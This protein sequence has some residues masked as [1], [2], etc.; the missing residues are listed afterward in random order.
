ML[1]GLAGMLRHAPE[2]D[3][4]AHKFK[5]SGTGEGAGL[6]PYSRL[7]RYDGSSF[8]YLRVWL[9]NQWDPAD[10]SAFMCYASLLFVASASF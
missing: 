3:R 2:V 6:Q 1:F 5:H 10:S 9:G 4:D 7:T 8:L